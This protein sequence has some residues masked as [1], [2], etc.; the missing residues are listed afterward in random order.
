M[1]S[2]ASSFSAGASRSTGG[3][4]V[5]SRLAAAAALNMCPVLHSVARPS[6]PACPPARG[7]LL[8]PLPPLLS[9]SGPSGPPRC[10]PGLEPSLPLPKKHGWCR[11]CAHVCW[12]R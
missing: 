3:T 6:R 11:L 1:S 4:L 2:A 9:P 8:L 12:A 7:A 5:G 10:L